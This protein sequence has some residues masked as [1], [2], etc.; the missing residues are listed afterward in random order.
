MGDMNWEK[1]FTH[2]AD[3]DAEWAEGG[4]RPT[5]SAPSSRMASKD[6]GNNLNTRKGILKMKM[7]RLLIGIGIIG[8]AAMTICVTWFFV[9]PWCFG[10]AATFF[11]SLVAGYAASAIV[12]CVGA[13]I[14]VQVVTK[15]ILRMR[16]AD[17]GGVKKPHPILLASMVLH[18]AVKFVLIV[19]LALFVV[20]L[21][22]HFVAPHSK[23]VA[24]V[25]GAVVACLGIGIAFKEVGRGVRQIRDPECGARPNE[26]VSSPPTPG[27]E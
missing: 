27:E 18:L 23:V 2:L 9:E 13:D 17:S 26:R 12:K 6:I 14:V 7:R 22:F 1:N 4:R 5:E 21:A 10:F 19:V 25:V 15:G 20:I 16:T 8:I 24:C 3:G 11:N